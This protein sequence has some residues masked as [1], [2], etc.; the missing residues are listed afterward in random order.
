M[1][2]QFAKLAFTPTVRALQTE[3]GSRN[4]YR[5]MDEGEDYNHKLGEREASFIEARDSFYMASVSETGWP[6]I[7]HRGG[8]AGFMKVLDES[9]LG[10]ADYSG[11]RQYVSIGNFANNDRVAFFF[12]D[13]PNQRRLKLLGRIEIFDTNNSEHLIDANYAA[14]VERGFRVKVE[15]FDWNCPQHITRRFSEAEIRN[16][17]L[18]DLRNES[19]NTNKENHSTPEKHKTADKDAIGSGPLALK[20]TAIRQLSDHVR[21]Y[22]FRSVDGTALPRVDAGT[23]IRIP[24]RLADGSLVDREYSISSDPAQTHFYE[25]A[26]LYEQKGRGASKAI[27]DSFTLGTRINADQPANLFPLH[28]DDRPAVL[29]A[30]GIGITPIRAM[31][32]SLLRNKTPLALHY[33]SKSHDDFVFE[34]ELEELLGD[35]LHLYNSAK[36]ERINL[37]SLLQESSEYSIFY[38]CGPETLINE[39]R[40]IGNHLGIS[41]ERIRFELFN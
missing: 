2:H 1:A 6:Y 29:I 18:S 24:I 32:F 19:I 14:Q 41:T 20:I 9:H 11:N 25:I 21:A 12:M 15:A 4:S 3:Y 8:P 26:V 23:H 30:G 27:H 33:A 16:T 22:E 38:V 31:A 39:V 10:F 13:Y 35:Q 5:P 36:G 40:K 17:F 7:Q 37:S 34:A 28:K